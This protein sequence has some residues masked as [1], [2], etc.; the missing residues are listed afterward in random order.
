MQHLGH[1]GVGFQ[2]APQPRD[3]DVDRAA[4]RVGIDHVGQFGPRDRRI[5]PGRQRTHQFDLGRGQAHA[6]FALS[7][8]TRFDVIGE[9]PHPE[10]LGCGGFGRR[11]AVEHLVDLVDQRGRLE[12]FQQDLALARFACRDQ[13]QRRGFGQIAQRCGLGHILQHDQVE[14][15]PRQQALRMVYIPRGG[16][17]EAMSTEKGLEQTA[18][19]LIRVDQKQMRVRLAHSGS[20]SALKWRRMSGSIIASSTFR[21]PSTASGPTSR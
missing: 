12:R 8:G 3:L 7:Q 13:P 15:Q 5:G 1:L 20:F 9:R 2:L 16:D 11:A 6:R 4:C 19:G 21:N 14:I 10:H 18:L 17:E